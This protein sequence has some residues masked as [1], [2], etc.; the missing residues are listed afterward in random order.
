M[1]KATLEVL[2]IVESK[3][4]LASTM[5][6]TWCDGGGDRWPVG[7]TRR[8]EQKLLA[9]GNRSVELGAAAAGMTLRPHQERIEAAHWSEISTEELRDYP[10]AVF[11]SWVKS[12][13]GCQKFLNSK[14]SPFILTALDATRGAMLLSRINL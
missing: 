4:T 6:G 5:P 7:L 2:E 10:T 14:P 3:T 12:F 11:H 8:K 1:Q 9:E 13:D